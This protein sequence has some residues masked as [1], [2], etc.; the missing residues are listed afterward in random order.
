MNRKIHEF[1]EKYKSLVEEY[2]K[3]IGTVLIFAEYKNGDGFS[4]SFG[5]MSI[6]TL[7]QLEMS[8]F[9][10]KTEYLE[11]ERSKLEVKDV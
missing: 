6:K 11:H 1:E 5:S 9:Q 7:G 3:D 2:K 10:M 4:R 8:V